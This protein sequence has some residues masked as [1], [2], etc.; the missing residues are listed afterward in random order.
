MKDSMLH[1][2]WQNS[3]VDRSKNLSGKDFRASP[4]GVKHMDVLN[5]KHSSSYGLRR[6]G[7][8]VKSDALQYRIGRTVNFKYLKV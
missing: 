8:N 3:S 2:S 6:I 5:K 4:A 1:C 7:R